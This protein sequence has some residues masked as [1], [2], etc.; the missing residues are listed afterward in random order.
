MYFLNPTSVPAN[1]FSRVELKD[2]TQLAS[3][4]HSHRKRN[5]V[6]WRRVPVTHG[7]IRAEDQGTSEIL[8][9]STKGVLFSIQQRTTLQSVG[10]SLQQYQ[11]PSCARTALSDARLAQ[12]RRFGI[13]K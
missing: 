2:Q 13:P 8:C 1:S 11:S 6:S 7:R 5:G 9:G 3:T 12:A 10:L 4:E